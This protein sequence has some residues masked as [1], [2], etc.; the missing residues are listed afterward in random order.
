MEPVPDAGGAR[1]RAEIRERYL[2]SA[3][4][5]REHSA[6]HSEWAA[7]AAG[8]AAVLD[9]LERV[10]ADHRQPSLLFSVCA[11]LGAPL[12]SWRPL[13]AWLLEHADAVV[14]EA[15]ARR[16]QTNEVGRCGPLAFALARLTGPVAL[17]ELGASAGLCLAVDRYGYRFRHAGDGS[18][19]L[20]G[21]GHPRVDVELA[22]GLPVPQRMPRVVTRVGVDLDPLDPRRPQD[23]AWLEALIPPDRPDRLARLRA[24]LTAALHH[25]PIPILRGDAL[26]TLPLLGR[27]WSRDLAEGE[28]SPAAG[29]VPPRRRRVQT[30]S[31]ASVTPVVVCLGTAVYLPPADRGR[32]VPEVAALGARLVTLEGAAVLPQVA[33]RLPRATT[34]PPSFVLALDGRPLAWSSAH[35]DRLQ[36]IAVSGGSGPGSGPGPDH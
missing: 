4:E 26:A 19:R 7:A 27:G 14:A 25:P 30:A 23:A 36:P 10:P 15:A 18:E 3:G 22:P 20:L 34:P 8:D 32:L 5:L 9:I 2:R 6:R 28:T 31:A 35:G 12:G 29:S 24:A 33:A 1:A 16:T 21:S 17:I 13:R 11:V